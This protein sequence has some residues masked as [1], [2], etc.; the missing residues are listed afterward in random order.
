MTYWKTRLQI[1]FLALDN[2]YE[3]AHDMAYVWN[4]YSMRKIYRNDYVKK[5]H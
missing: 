5:N 1:V 2:Q 3:E 4:L